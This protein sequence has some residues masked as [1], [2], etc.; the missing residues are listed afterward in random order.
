M[1]VSIAAHID[2]DIIDSKSNTKSYNFTEV[3]LKRW[4]CKKCLWR[5]N[6]IFCAQIPYS[7]A[8]TQNIL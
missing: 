7:R 4:E 6:I 2:P 1:A 3:R 5:Q 8:L